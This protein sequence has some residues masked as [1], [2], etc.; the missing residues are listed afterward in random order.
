MYVDKKLANVLEAMEINREIQIKTEMRFDLA[1]S[2][3]ITRSSPRQLVGYCANT[4]FA[5]DLLHSIGHRQRN[6]V[7]YLQ[8]SAPFQTTQ[9]HPQ[10]G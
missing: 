4:K 9:T 10:A 5:K 7:P 1:H 3:A 2:A 6:V 8:V